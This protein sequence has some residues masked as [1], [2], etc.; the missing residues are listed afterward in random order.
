[1]DDRVSDVT[2]FLGR[3][4]TVLVKSPLNY[5]GGK[6]RLLPQILPLMP[7]R[8]CR[9]YDLFT[10]GGTVAAN[11]PGE[12]VLAR[13][14]VSDLVG[15]LNW[16]V[17][18]P[19]GEVEA[20]VDALVA[21]YGLSES[22]RYG[23][24]RYGT[25]SGTGL[26]EVN[27]DA[28]ARLVAAHHCARPGEDPDRRAARFFALVIY[29]Y[30]H[31]IR[32]NAQGRWNIAVG[33]RDFNARIRANLAAFCRALQA[34]PT[35][36]VLGSY[37]AIDLRRVSCD[38]YLYADP[39]YLLGLAAYNERRAWTEAH[40]RRLFAFLDRA[41]ARGIRFGLS[42]VLVHKGRRHVLLDDW[43]RDRG[44]RI[45]YLEASYANASYRRLGR[46]LE[47]REVFVCNYDLPLCR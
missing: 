11:A 32:F 28:Y 22:W 8:I 9:F 1:M 10:G 29:G 35:R 44:Y 31:Q 34:R 6:F 3:P 4:G 41:H 46:D 24:A 25:D 23:Y 33:K 19:A 37:E 36:F 17:R 43:V 40:E 47:D 5:T 13:D 16:L 38:D 30:N 21:R 20:A 2:T 45:Y 18:T 7:R 15:F 14:V 27:R 26:A 39:P 42:N 12:C